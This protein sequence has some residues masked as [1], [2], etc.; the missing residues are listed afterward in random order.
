VNKHILVFDSGLGGTTILKEIQNRLPENAYS[1]AMDNAAFPY[2]NKSNVFL[3]ERSIKLFHSLI[4]ESQPDLIVIA[5]NTASTLILDKLRNHFDIPFVGVVPAIKPAAALSNT[6]VIGL[7][8]T[9]A[10]V[11]RDYIKQLND[12]HANNCEVIHFGCQGLVDV[13]EKKI[14]GLAVNSFTLNAEMKELLNHP[15]SNKIDV[16]ILGCTHFPA[17]KDEIAALWPY[18]SLWID[19][20]EAIAN[21]VEKL[22]QQLPSNKYSRIPA[23]YL[24]QEDKDDKLLKT[25]NSYGITKSQVIKME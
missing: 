14:R 5:C 11:G 12:A 18:K 15:L 7:L 22:C 13:A 16:F 2:G 9:E 25:F 23:L 8:A 24:S 19:S 3:L 20:G 21:R 10:T 1:Y 17:I 6:K 4:E